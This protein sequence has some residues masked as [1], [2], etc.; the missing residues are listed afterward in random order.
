MNG[1][2]L[3]VELNK[4]AGNHGIGRIDPTRRAEDITLEEW[5]ALTNQLIRKQEKI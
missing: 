4:I 1:I 3:I 2:E 5:G